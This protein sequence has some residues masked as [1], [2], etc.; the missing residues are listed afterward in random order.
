MDYIG[1]PAPLGAGFIYLSSF[2]K[3]HGFKILKYLHFNLAIISS[4]HVEQADR[5]LFS[6]SIFTEESFAAD[7]LRNAVTLYEHWGIVEHHRQD[8]IR[9]LYLSDQWNSDNAVDS[10]INMVG[11]YRR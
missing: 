10:V 7:T 3:P 6:F 11:A 1:F 5:K 2:Q 8:G 4:C 9:I